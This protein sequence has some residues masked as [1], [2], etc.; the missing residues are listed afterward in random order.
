S[1]K[2]VT[3]TK[4][5]YRLYTPEQITDIIANL[6]VHHEIP[7][8]YNY[9]DK[10][11]VYWDEYSTKLFNDVDANNYLQSTEQFMLLSRP[12]LDA[13]LGEYKKINVVD[14]GPGNALPVKSLLEHLLNQ[15]RLGRYTA[16]D[17]SPEMLGIAH[18]NIKQW[19]GNKV[20][21]VADLRDVSFER[22]TD[23]LMID[24]PDEGTVNLVLFFGVTLHNLRSIDEALRT[25]YHSMAP[26]DIFILPLKLDTE[27]TRRNFHF[28]TGSRGVTLPPQHKF[29]VDLLGI[30]SALYDVEMD[31]DEELRQRYLRLRLKYSLTISIEHQGKTQR[32]TFDKGDTL[33]VWRCWHQNAQEIIAQLEKNGFGV[34]QTMQTKEHDCM[35]TI[36]DIK[37]EH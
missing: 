11:A 14:I 28:N 12:Y 25:I 20:D 6:R 32:I 26:P 31:F 16:I 33:L 2:T 3:P 19:F 23:L 27:D 24:S 21:F 10:G 4:D 1:Q 9:M 29:L 37:P 34:L 36:A 15:D 5:F 13:R 30:E 22:F 17:I 7:R 8:Q 35:L 18:R